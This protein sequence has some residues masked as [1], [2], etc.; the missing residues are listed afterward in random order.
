V[1]LEQVPRLAVRTV[2]VKI[3]MAIIGVGRFV[4]ERGVAVFKSE[5]LWIWLP[6]GL[7]IAGAWPF[8]Q[9]LARVHEPNVLDFNITTR[10]LPN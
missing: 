8:R 3:P 5:L 1:P 7:V 2:G 9:S 4:T 6:A 10:L